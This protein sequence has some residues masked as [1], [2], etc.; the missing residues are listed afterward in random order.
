MTQEECSKLIGICHANWPMSYKGMTSNDFCVLAGIW[1]RILAGYDYKTA[2]AGLLAYAR[3]ETKGFPPSV[4]QLID[5]IE[6]L[7]ERQNHDA[8]MTAQEAW[9]LVRKAISNSAYHSKAE[10]EALPELC[11]KAVGSPGNLEALAMSTI[12]TIDSVEKSHFIRTYNT[13][14]S[15]QRE[16]AKINVDLIKAISEGGACVTVDQISA[17]TIAAKVIKDA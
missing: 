17:G 13:L 4:G 14:I 11:R 10:F 9:G 7:R 15:R 12:D 5:C 16:D 8:C 1:C 6:K 2:E 3:V